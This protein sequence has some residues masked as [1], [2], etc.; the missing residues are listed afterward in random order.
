MQLGARVLGAGLS[1]R[2]YGFRQ[3]RSM[4]DLIAMFVDL[5]RDSI[6]VGKIVV[7]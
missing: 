2:Q 1:E 5:I 6:S 7:R 4:V 3:A